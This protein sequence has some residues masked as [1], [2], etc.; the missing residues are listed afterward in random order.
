MEHIITKLVQDFEEGKMTRRQLIKSLTIAAS[1]AATGSAASAA[2]APE[3]YVA[4]VTAFNHVSYQ[5]SDYKKCRDFYAG[6]FGM[7]V[8]MD[9]GMQCRLSFGDNI[10][11]VR[12][13]TPNPKVDH[14]AY[15]IA[16]WDT[17]KS[18]KPAV[19]AELKRRGLQIRTTEGSFHVS[20]PEGFEVQMGGKNQ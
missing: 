10:L 3:R 4:K 7:E 9:D 17:D 16:G 14:I 6:L 8:S 15:S 13:R 19:E 5:V 11:I 20:D 12:N 2:P 18:V 1:A